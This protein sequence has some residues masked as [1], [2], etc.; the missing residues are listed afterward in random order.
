MSNLPSITVNPETSPIRDVVKEKQERIKKYRA[1]AS[2]MA[3]VANKRIQR[4]EAN[5]MENSPAYQGYLASG[6][7]KFSVSGKTFQEVQAEVGRINRLIKANTSTVRGFN[8]YTKDLAAETGIKY[9]TLQDAREQLAV[10]FEMQNKLA[11]YLPSLSD[12]AAALDYQKIWEAINTY[13]DQTNQS[14]QEIGTDLDRAIANIGN[15]I[16]AY[17][18]PQLETTIGGSSNDPE[19]SA[20]V[21]L[22][23]D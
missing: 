20:W 17:E 8:K 3:S 19:E 18:T 16:L 13:R 15:A 5:G 6:G 12:L 21:W 4:L 22:S 2:K 7:G 10:L 14:L 23:R 9:K 11:Q 1:E